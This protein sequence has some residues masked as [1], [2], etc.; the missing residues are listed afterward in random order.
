MN[1]KKSLSQITFFD[2][3]LGTHIEDGE[4]DCETLFVN[5][6]QITTNGGG[7]SSIPS[8]SYVAGPPSV[9]TIT[10]N[11]VLQN[12]N[13]FTSAI[14][15]NALTQTASLS[16]PA[17]TQITDL[18]NNLTTTNNNLTTANNNITTL[19][20]KTQK[21][22][23]NSTSTTFTGETNLENTNIGSS[24]TAK[25]LTLYGQMTLSTGSYLFANSATISDVEISRL[26]G[27]SSNIQD[28]INNANNA[29]S[30][31]D[32][33]ISNI[34]DDIG[35][36]NQH[37]TDLDAGL[38]AVGITAGGA[39]TLA[40]VA[41]ATALSALTLAGTAEGLAIGANERC[42]LLETKTQRQDFLSASGQEPDRT[43]FNS[44]VVA[45]RVRTNTILS[46]IG[47]NLAFNIGGTAS[48][49]NGLT[50]GSAFNQTG[51]ADINNFASDTRFAN[52]VN[53]NQNAGN[54]ALT[55][56]NCPT[57]FNNINYFNGKSNYFYAEIPAFPASPRAI[58]YFYTPLLLYDNM[59]INGN[60][61]MEQ[62][63]T[64]LC[65]KII[66]N[67]LMVGV[68]EIQLNSGYAVGTENLRIRSNMELDP[69]YTFTLNGIMNGATL[70]FGTQA[71]CGSAEIATN[72]GITLRTATTNIISTTTNIS[73]NVRCG[74]E[75][76][77][78]ATSLISY[79]QFIL[80]SG[81]TLYEDITSTFKDALI[82]AE[83][84][85]GATSDFIGTLNMVAQQ[86]IYTNINKIFYRTSFATGFNDVEIT[87][88]P[89]YSIQHGGSY[90]IQSAIQDLE[91]P[92]IYIGKD[93]NSVVECRGTFF[94]ENIQ[95]GDGRI[96]MPDDI[97]AQF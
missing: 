15:T 84:L 47:S 61:T 66:A 88:I 20:G 87:I 7:G 31:N 2:D 16:S 44:D 39:A 49:S 76:Q 75:T 60:I 42:S 25:T 96:D 5:G 78:T 55:T 34:Q 85:A 58:T 13:G 50:C 83:K 59:E 94:C 73:N 52:D 29:I 65:N 89:V 35:D 22:S 62:N 82:Y 79:G 33:D 1:C 9:T 8:I 43:L 92:I 24:T 67:P 68:D 74:D 19:Q 69:N 95:S 17:Q 70:N 11:T 46:D 27:V 51:L 32:N 12:L 26:D 72:T 18:S 64:L 14:F 77:T 3:G 6:V 38:T 93:A 28:Q 21:Q 48:F 63:K 80:R 40:G 23:A 54:D 53:F 37:L 45:T 41:E 91:S 71:I 81:L 30:S 56:F 4:V 57:Q 36:I 10:G 90:K 97:F 86:F